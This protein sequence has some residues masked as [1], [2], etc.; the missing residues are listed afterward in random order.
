[1]AQLFLSGFHTLCAVRPPDDRC[2][3]MA[4]ED[5]FDNRS[6]APA[7]A[8]SGQKRRVNLYHYDSVAAQLFNPYGASIGTDMDGA[9]THGFSAERRLCCAACLHLEQ[10]PGTSGVAEG[11]QVSAHHLWVR[12]HDASSPSCHP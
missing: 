6:E 12:D 1:M 9:C 10:D 8:S 4:G 11:L 3:P 5:L 7:P 2:P